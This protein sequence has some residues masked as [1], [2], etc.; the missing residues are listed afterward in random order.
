MGFSRV[1]VH[2]EVLLNPLKTSSFSVPVGDI[3]ASG[4]PGCALVLVPCV[5]D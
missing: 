4:V 3:T 2:R 1:L 5:G